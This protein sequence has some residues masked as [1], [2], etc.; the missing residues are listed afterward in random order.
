MIYKSFYAL[1]DS[2]LRQS[3]NNFLNKTWWSSAVLL[4][5]SQMVDLQY[6]DGRVS[7]TLWLLLSGLLSIMQDKDPALDY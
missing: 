3:L 7:M 2:Y 6:Y 1:N 5:V 4:L